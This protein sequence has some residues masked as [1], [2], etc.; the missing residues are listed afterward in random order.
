MALAVYPPQSSDPAKPLV[1][2]L[3]GEGGW[4]SFDD[5]LA[6]W[7]AEAGYCT[8]QAI[9]VSGGMVMH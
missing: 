1:L 4:R 8:G 9:N 5:T 3:S 6:R 7:F 2:V